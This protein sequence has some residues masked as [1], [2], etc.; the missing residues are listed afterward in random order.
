MHPFV[1]G[2]FHS[3][4]CVFYSST[5]SPIAVVY[6]FSL[7]KSIALNQC[8]NFSLFFFFVQL[9]MD[10]WV[11][12]GFELLQIAVLW[13]SLIVFSDSHIHTF[14]LDLY[15]R[16]KLLLGHKLCVYSAVVL[17]DKQFSKVVVFACTLGN[18]NLC[19][20]KLNVSNFKGSTSS[21]HVSQQC[22]RGP[23]FHILPNMWYYQ[24][25]RLAILVSVVL[26]LFNFNFHFHDD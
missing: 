26:S 21:L 14:L 13:T 1:S 22:M 19:R 17:A 18:C 23:V 24:C 4:L 25:F 16:V 2:S 15:L 3:I 12:Y 20:S 6:S 8:H 9:M 7:L 5:W 10:I 11:F